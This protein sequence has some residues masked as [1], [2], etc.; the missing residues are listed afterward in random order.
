MILI[1]H[2]P[3]SSAAIFIAP[4]FLIVANA[5]AQTLPS[6]VI[7]VP[8]T[9]PAIGDDESIGS[10]TTLNVLPG[11]SVGRSFDA[12]AE[13]GTSTNV[14]VNITGGTVDRFFVA[15]SGSQINISGGIIDDFFF[16]FSNSE[17]NLSGGSVGTR[18]RMGSEAVGNIYGNEFRLNGAPILNSIIDLE[19][20]DIFTGTLEDGSPFIFSRDARDSLRGVNLV[21]AP[22]PKIADMHFSVD[23][24]LDLAGLRA[25]QTLTLLDEGALKNKNFAVVG[26]TLNVTGGTVER[27]ES[28]YSEINIT[29]GTVG[30]FDF[31]RFDEFSMNAFAGSNVNISGGTVGDNLRAFSGSVVNI[32]GGTVGIDFHGDTVNISGGTI[33]DEFGGRF[34]DISGGTVG[35]FFGGGIVNI[36]NGTVGDFFSGYKVSMTGGTVGDR[37]TAVSGSEINIAGG[38]VGDNFQAQ[39]GSVV[40]ISGGT[41]GNFFAAERSWRRLPQRS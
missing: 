28:A 2:S 41:V 22:V 17:V 25:G 21:S 6:G 31:D 27:L 23:S 39:L 14:V 12:G 9:F 7:N 8:G 10:D 5:T 26:A 20:P 38:T 16:T 18:F 3:I 24:E 34:V 30:N 13:D 33:G 19:R 4:L 37:F 11:G 36:T 1:R 40:N 15:R 29:G 32:S 35:D